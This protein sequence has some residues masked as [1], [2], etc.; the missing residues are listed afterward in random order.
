M[1]CNPRR[2]WRNSGLSPQH[3]GRVLQRNE[4]TDFAFLS[5][6]HLDYRRA[7][8]GL[9][10][11]G[12]WKLALVV[13]NRPGDGSNSEQ[14]NYQLYNTATNAGF[15][16]L[17][18]QKDPNNVAT[19]VYLSGDVPTGSYISCT[20]LSG[21]NYN[22]TSQYSSAFVQWATFN[23]QYGDFQI[24]AKLGYGWPTIW[25]MGKNCQGTMPITPSSINGCDWDYP[26]SEEID[27]SEGSSVSAGA[28]QISHSLHTSAT[29]YTCYT[30]SLTDVTKNYHVY[31]AVVTS[32]K[33]T[34]FVDG[35][36]SCST[37]NSNTDYWFLMI[38]QAIGGNLGGN[39][40]S[41]AYPNST[42]VDW[43]KVCASTCSN[44]IVGASAP[45]VTF[46]DDFTSATSP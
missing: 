45:D 42:S 32:N 18:E 24:R 36:Q 44:G 39:P 14:E 11:L 31:E 1:D 25:M 28:T 4:R 2:D 27:I 40:A 20:L 13:L 3:R 34:W 29:N 21:N 5:S 12:F 37:S 10:G 46:F 9:S 41:F 7:N 30:S 19:G 8:I 26:G 43:V 16:T 22:C 23:Q 35:V 38:N 15:L 17:T 33:I 6:V